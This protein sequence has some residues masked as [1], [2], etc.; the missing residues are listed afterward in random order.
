MV[1]LRSKRNTD[2]K[3]A[4]KMPGVRRHSYGENTISAFS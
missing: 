1:K 3:L 4:K 2:K